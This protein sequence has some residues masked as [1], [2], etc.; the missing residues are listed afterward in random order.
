MK[1]KRAQ[2]RNPSGFRSEES[3][4]AFLSNLGQ[5]RFKTINGMTTHIESLLY[6]NMVF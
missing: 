1:G 2:A 5:G 6:A 4:E 3:G